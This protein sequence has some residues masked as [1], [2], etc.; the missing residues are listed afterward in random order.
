[1]YEYLKEE[2]EKLSE[3]EKNALMI[4]K[5]RLG[6]AIN[7]MNR[8]DEIY[9]FYKDIINDPKNIFLKM[10]VFKDID[11]SNVISF[12]ES[13]DHIYEIVKKATS[14]I[15]LKE[16]LTVYRMVSIKD[17][18]ELK[19]ISKGTV[20]STS[21]NIDTCSKFLINEE[22]YKHYLYQINLEKGSKVGICPYS[23]LYNR[24]DNTVTLSKNSDQEEIIINKYNYSFE[25][26]DVHEVSLDNGIVLNIISYDSKN[27]ELNSLQ[28]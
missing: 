18:E 11:F 5:S 10:S 21:I 2:F 25:N 20:I 16:D 14:K 19:D 6:L 27:K 1:M 15:I 17:D 8:I 7:D 9:Y 22:G 23:I 3:E 12:S 4:Y 26:K 13:L 24:G 28:R